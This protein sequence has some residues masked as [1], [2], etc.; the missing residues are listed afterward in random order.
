MLIQLTCPTPM[1]HVATMLVFGRAYLA[2]DQQG[3]TLE[4]RAEWMHERNL[5]IWQV[6]AVYSAV[7]AQW[8][9]DP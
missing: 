7:H 2:A 8:H 1:H 9:W 3:L 5:L 4:E 6:C